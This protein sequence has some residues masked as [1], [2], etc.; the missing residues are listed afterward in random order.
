[1]K[2]KPAIDARSDPDYNVRAALKAQ[3]R[4]ETEKV[5][6]AVRAIGDVFYKHVGMMQKIF[7]EFTHMTHQNFVTCEQIHAALLKIGFAFDAED[8]QR[9]VLFVIPD[10]DLDQIDYVHFIQSLVACYHDLC[11]IR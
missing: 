10:C 1:M 5:R 3:E 4:S 11:S 7:K 8:V 9:C 6:K 2:M